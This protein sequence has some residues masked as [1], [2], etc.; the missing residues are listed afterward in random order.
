M[1]SSALQEF[2]RMVEW[3]FIRVVSATVSLMAKGN[4]LIAED[5]PV[6]RNLYIRKFTVAGFDL[7]T[8]ENGQQALDAIQQ[9]EPDLVA[10]DIHMPVMDGFEV[11]KRLPP[12]R[13][14]FPIILLTN[15]ADAETHDRGK[16]LGADD[17]FVKKDMTIR[18]LIDMVD[19]LIA[20][21]KKL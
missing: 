20:N 16:E 12:E 3:V 19:R 7:R 18:T 13:R 9:Q 15:F 17:Y 5:D 1:H 11:L 21:R 10:L 4:I 8:A 2:Q 6:L 14:R